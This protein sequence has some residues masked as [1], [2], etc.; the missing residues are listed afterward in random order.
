MV[1]LRLSIKSQSSMSGTGLWV[2]WGGGGGWWL[3]GGWVVGGGGWLEHVK[4]YFSVQH[5]SS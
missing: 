2:E 3:S 5:S 1:I 4:T